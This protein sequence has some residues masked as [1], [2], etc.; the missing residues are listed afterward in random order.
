VTFRSAQRVAD[1]PFLPVGVFKA[2]P[3]LALVPHSEVTRTLTSSATTGQ[4]PSRVSLDAGTARRMTRG[5][6]S[7]V[8]DFI[9]PARRALSGHRRT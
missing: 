6:T 2:D 8:R 7:I 1:L 9:G 5:V 4:V 3:P